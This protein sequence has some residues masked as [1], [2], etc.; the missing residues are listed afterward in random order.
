MHIGAITAI[1]VAAL[2]SA[3]GGGGG[4]GASP[5]RPFR[6]FSAIQPGDTVMAEGLSQT[7]SA[8]TDMS[9]KVTSATVNAVDTG[10]SNVRLSYGAGLTLT[11]I[12]IT[13]PQSSVSWSAANISCGIVICAAANDSAA[14]AAI[15]AYQF[16][17]NYQTFGYWLADTGA[18]TGVVGVISIGNPTPV[19]SI[20]TSGTATYTGLAAGIYVDDVG[21]V[22]DYAATT[23]ATANFGVARNVTLSTDNS[24]IAPLLG[25]GSIVDTPGLNFSGTNLPITPAANEFKGPVATGAPL[26]LTGTATGRF[27]G[28]AAEEIGGVFSLTGT[29]VQGLIGAF[30]GRR[31]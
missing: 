2:L 18:T 16:G 19:N 4:G 3:C 8:T 7:A 27:Y 11:G 22:Y 23:S 12:A 10:G 21:V 20:P 9:G 17:W 25:G 24:K 15:D 29:G 13:T 1:L 28:P 14:G 31:P 30:G 26:N 5:V 6:S